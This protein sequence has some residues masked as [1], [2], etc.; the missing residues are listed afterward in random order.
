MQSCGKLSTPHEP[1]LATIS[2]S[3]S[4]LYGCIR[5]WHRFFSYS[6][7]QAPVQHFNQT[8]VCSIKKVLVAPSSF[9]CRFAAL[10]SI[11]VTMTLES[12]GIQSSRP[13]QGLHDH[14][15]TT[16]LTG[17]FLQT[18]CRAS[19]PSSWQPFETSHTCS[20]SSW[21]YCHELVHLTC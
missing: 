5:L 18:R 10:L 15:C 4:F 1:L 16:T 21:W 7:L 19:E 11:T 17:A 12:F 9:W 20:V 3:N 6:S 14:P 13:T 2:W 8:E